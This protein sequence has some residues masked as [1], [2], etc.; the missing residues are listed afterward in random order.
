MAYGK[1]AGWRLERIARQVAGVAV[2]LALVV[3]IPGATLRSAVLLSTATCLA[4]LAFTMLD[5]ARLRGSGLGPI[6]LFSMSLAVT[7]FAN[8]V[9]LLSVDGDDSSPYFIYVASDHLLLASGLLLVGGVAVILGYR[10]QMR[11]RSARAITG[12][13]PTVGATFG[14]RALVIGGSAVALLGMLAN[15]LPT[16]RSL[17]TIN[18]IVLLTP[19]LVVFVLAR[20]GFSRDLRAAKRTA[21]LIALAEAVRA[22]LFEY[23]RSAIL[24]PL[25]AFVVGAVVATRSLGVMRSRYFVPIY[26]GVIGFVLSF[27]ALGHV[28]VTAG[29]G[30]ARLAAIVALQERERAD[31][32]QPRHTLLGRLTSFNQLSQVG[33][34][35]EEDGFLHGQTLEY[36]GY[37]FVPRFLWPGKPRI[38]KGA[39][40]AY[41]IGQAYALPDGRYSNS[42]N[43]TVP[44][45]LYLNFGWPG[46]LIGCPLFGAIL[47]ALW[48]TTRFWT[49]PRNVLGTAF[50]FY[51]LWVAFGLGADLQIIVTLIAMYLLF[52]AGSVAARLVQHAGRTGHAAGAPEVHSLG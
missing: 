31:G 18:A 46:V 23:L 17:G 34:V 41:R 27:A 24:T 5:L 45:E 51:L 38:A 25:F 22:A 20:V 47:A 39:W 21:L 43:M 3:G 11:L 37:A 35:V 32:G 50:G 12:L 7:G 40:F 49:E 10:A 1:P 19:N 42:I 52:L 29:E 16:T 2:W 4:G 26:A 6:T 14:D 13:L 8:T 36:L 15:F 33:R 44:G 28:R 30:M 9:G 48:S